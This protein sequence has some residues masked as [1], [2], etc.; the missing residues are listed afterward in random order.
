MFELLKKTGKDWEDVAEDILRI[1]S[2]DKRDEIRNCFS[3]DDDHLRES[4][5]F[6]L[7]WCTFASY[8]WLAHFDVSTE[9]V[10]PL[11]GENRWVI[12]H[13]LYILIALG[14]LHDYSV[15]RL[16]HAMLQGLNY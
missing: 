4:I 12:G 16:N 7:K 6:W 14:V 11:P 5:R 13:V 3:T 15:S 10:E 2:K 1:L 9:F 8:R